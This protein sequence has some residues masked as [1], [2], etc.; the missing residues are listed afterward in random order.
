MEGMGEKKLSFA[1]TTKE[2]NGIFTNLCAYG[3]D[4]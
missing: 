2:E 3:L 4:G 1:P